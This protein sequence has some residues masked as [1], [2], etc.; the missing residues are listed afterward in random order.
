[1]D[2]AVAALDAQEVRLVASERNAGALRAAIDR[3][4]SDLEALDATLTEEDVAD[5]VRQLS[6][7]EERNRPPLQEHARISD[8]KR[9]EISRQLGG[10][11]A[12][13]AIH[14]YDRGSKAAR[15]A[16]AA[17]GLG[18]QRLLR[19]RDR[20]LVREAHEMSRS[21]FWSDDDA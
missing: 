18:I 16:L 17:F 19:L 4:V 8:L 7:E 10:P 14:L 9:R 12:N 15:L 21:T 3:Y 11:L 1:M 5:A 13:R 20:V 2:D 6:K